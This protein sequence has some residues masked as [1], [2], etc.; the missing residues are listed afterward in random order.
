MI[1]NI[2]VTRWHYNPVRGEC[3][4]FQYGG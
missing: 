3:E 1:N 4:P 2:L